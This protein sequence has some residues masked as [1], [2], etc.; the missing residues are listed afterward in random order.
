MRD[1]TVLL[2]KSHG[3]IGW[4]IKRVTG[5]PWGHAAK[6]LAGFTWERT[7]WWS[8]YWFK[9]GI[10]IHAGIAAADEYWDLREDMTPEQVTADL[11]Y[12]IDQLNSRRPYNIPKLIVKAL[13]IPLRRW[14]DRKGWV[15]F[16]NPI[17]GDDCSTTVAESFD[18][19]GINILPEIP[20]G[21][22][23]PGDF[24]KSPLLEKV[25]V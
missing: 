4:C 15:P 1:G 6:Y 16:D 5:M 21:R 7:L 13:V 10:R 24:R 18:A 9:S 14:F 23:A 25:G 19:A 22:V 3:F 20:S 8:W 2:W 17:Y 11:T 12:W